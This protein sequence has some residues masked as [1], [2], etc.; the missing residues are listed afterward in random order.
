MGCP[1]N[2]VGLR[3]ADGAPCVAGGAGRA[4][5]GGGVRGCSGGAAGVAGCP[6]GAGAGAGWTGT[7]GGAGW[8]AAVPA[9]SATR[10]NDRKRELTMREMSGARFSL[11]KLPGAGADSLGEAAET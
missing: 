5:S 7:G 3:A 11:G 4:A 6:A 1:Q 10:I 8:A 9:I 2:I